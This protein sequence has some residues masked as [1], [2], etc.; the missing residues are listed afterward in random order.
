VRPMRS[1]TV[2]LRGAG[3][4]PGTAT[5]ATRG[6]VFLAAV[7]LVI[8]S[9]VLVGRGWFADSVDAVVLVDDAG[10]SLTT[11]ADVK[12]HGVIVGRVTSLARPAGSDPV[13]VGV[14]LDPDHAGGVPAD[15]VARVLPASVFGTSFVDLVSRAGSAAAA[16]ALVAGQ[17]IPQDRT[18]ETLEIQ[19]VL[20]GLDRVVGSLG[21]ARLARTLGAVSTALDGNGDRLGRVLVRVERYL[22]ELNPQLP[23]V[24]RNLDLLATNLRAFSRYAPDLFRATEDA[25]VAARTL[26][27]QDDR[28]RAVARSG[29]RAFGRTDRLLQENRSAL[30]QTLVR[31]AVAVDAMY[32]QRHEL[33]SA[34]LD[35]VGLSD[36][37]G[38]ALVQ[39]PYL[40]ID[41]DLA[42]TGKD[43]YTRRDCPEYGGHRGRGCR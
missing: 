33:V 24:R 1:L 32:D 7:A 30:A 11:G 12:Y 42:L 41:G 18:R 37:F 6:A 28:F 43:A 25:L 29:A 35:V 26:V 2:L 10:G 21:P 13:R 3:R 38:D 15:V 8:G 17:V 39:G 20:D 22:A 40:R 36:V 31:S 34:L 5:L 14:A 16:G 4:D 9:L 27:E 23:L 19:A